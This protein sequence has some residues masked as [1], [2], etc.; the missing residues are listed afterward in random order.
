[1]K[2]R[3]HTALTHLVLMLALALAAT[4]T[5]AADQDSP[6]QINI[7]EAEVEQLAYLPRIGPSLAQRIVD[8]REEN[9]KFE[10]TEDLILVRGIGE[11]TF[12]MLE[13]FVAVEG[14]TT[15]SRKLR[16]QDVEAVRGSGKGKK[17]KKPSSES[18]SDEADA[19]DESA[20]AAN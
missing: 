5:L 12:E 19:S 1:M 15:L 14:K 17:E 11:K 6:G 9:G 4:P 7:N 16:T 18:D 8:F 13:P 10:A 2:T 20:D 3:L